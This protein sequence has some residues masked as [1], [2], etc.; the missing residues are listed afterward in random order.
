MLR[1]LRLVGCI[2]IAS[3]AISCSVVAGLGDLTFK[4]CVGTCVDAAVGGDTGP[5]CAP[6]GQVCAT[7]PQC[8]C[9]ADQSC[10]LPLDDKGTGTT[11]C[12]T[13]GSSPANAS[14]SRNE[15]CAKGLWCRSGIC[16]PFCSTTTDCASF[17][18]SA[19]CEDSILTG[20]GKTVVVPNGKVCKSRCDPLAPAT[21]CPLGQ[22]CF[23]YQDAK[24]V[25]S[26]NCIGAGTGT[27]TDG[28]RTGSCA[29][30]YACTNRASDCRAYCEVGADGGCPA[31]ASCG[32][33][34]PKARIGGKEIGVCHTSCSPVSP[35]TA[36]GTDSCTLYVTGEGTAI[37][38]C[39][40]SG[41]TKAV[42]ETC[43]A[44]LD[45]ANGS[46]CDY[47]TCRKWCQVGA[48]GD[49]PSGLECMA[50]LVKVTEGTTTVTYG[51]CARACDPIVASSCGDPKS[52]CY[53]F[54]SAAEAITDCTPA[55]VAAI[56]RTC[57]S[58]A[59]C[60]PGGFCS[61]NAL[62]KKY[63]RIGTADCGAALC[64]PF[65]AHPN[66]KGVEYGFCGDACNP[67]APSAVCGPTNNCFLERVTTS[68]PWYT[69]CV[70]AGSGAAGA[71]CDEPFACSPGFNCVHYSSSDICRKFCRV[72]TATDCPSGFTCSEYEPQVTVG[73]VEYGFCRTN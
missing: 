18:P 35:A 8:G 41:G 11:E 3:T 68:S 16:R 15:E 1:S 72:G 55:G 47:G 2:A 65:D 9:G 57:S 70:P 24:G 43:T 60:A 19:V 14:C 50:Y 58:T 39:T 71:S 17:S 32:S 44:A 6:P 69:T 62:C 61:E 49:C 63:C 36:C 52:R 22:S 46:V 21:T 7:F 34:E 42:G 33:F 28:C 64:V 10:V 59:L 13:A 48:A 56:N 54:G 30:G 31:G 51:R 4:D 40:R 67:I 20:S 25:W 38:D 29:A 5:A 37:S 53:V 66:V 45:C 12:V 73:G 26:T 27:D 23:V